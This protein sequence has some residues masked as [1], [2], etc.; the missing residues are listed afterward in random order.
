MHEVLEL[1]NV[2]YYNLVK[3]YMIFKL[4]IKLGKIFRIGI[5]RNEIVDSGTIRNWHHRKHKTKNN[6]KGYK[7]IYEVKLV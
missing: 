1:N 3:Q 6:P 7:L 2:E 5:D 4:Y